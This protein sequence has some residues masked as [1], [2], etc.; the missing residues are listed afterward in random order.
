MP[1]VEL[2][3]IS[4]RYGRIVALDGVTLTIEDGE[5]VCIIGPSGSG[6]STL[7]KIIA[8]IVRPDAGRVLLDG[9]D[10]TNLPINKRGIGMVMQEVLLFPNMRIWENVAYSPMVGGVSAYEAIGIASEVLSDINLKFRSHS[11]PDELSRGLQQ[12]AAIARAIASGAKLLLMDEPLGSIDKREARRLRFE[13]RSMIKELGLTAIQVTHNQEEAMSVADRIVILR[14]GRVEQV[15]S[16]RHIYFNPKSLFIA[17]FIGGELNAVEGR[18]VRAH[19]DIVEVEAGNLGSLTA[20]NMEH[21][22]EGD[23][24]AVALRPEDLMVVKE[25]GHDFMGRVQ[26]VSLW[27][28][29]YEIGIASGG[30]TVIVRAP[31]NRWASAVPGEIVGVKVIRA[32]AFK[33]PKKG[34]EEALR[35]E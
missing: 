20:K 1:R 9:R 32:Y 28:E 23:R 31:R 30:T 19:G 13:L 11:F 10:V 14:R 3:N 5:Y 15:G 16:P 34:L 18:V 12:K 7:L 6:K 22:R 2:L 17:K 4:K 29:F 25:G 33:Y 27:G 8:G 21:L 24:A 35:Y 26:H